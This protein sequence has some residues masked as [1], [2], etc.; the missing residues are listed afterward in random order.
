MSP[1][2]PQPDFDQVSFTDDYSDAG[3]GL[4]DQQQEDWGSSYYDTEAQNY[5]YALEP[6]PGA[7]Y[8]YYEDVTLED[9]FMVQTSA[10]YAGSQD[11]AYGLIFNVQDDSHYYAFRVSGDAY[12]TVE[13][14]DG[15]KSDTLVD[16]LSAGPM[17][18]QEGTVNTLAVVGN[19]G[20]YQL[21]INGEEVGSFSDDSSTAAQSATW[22]ITSTPSKAPP[23]PSTTSPSAPRRNKRPT[24]ERPLR[25]TTQVA[26]VMPQASLLVA[27]PQRDPCG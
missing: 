19:S 7:I 17:G 5:V 15:D 10:Q 20:D 24:A 12:F 11:T 25:V 9:N 27:P 6:N 3:S 23:S 1:S 14:I 13:K 21:Y 8:D 18:T 16:W 2:A 22:S 4:Y 26:L